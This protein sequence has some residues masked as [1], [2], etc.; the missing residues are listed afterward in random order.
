MFNETQND[1][2][3]A[4]QSITNLLELER[5]MGFQDLESVLGQIIGLDEQT[6]GFANFVFRIGTE[7]GEFFLKHRAPYIKVRPNLLR[8]RER[9][10]HEIE[11]VKVLSQILPIGTS[12]KLVYEDPD[13]F[14]FVIESLLKENGRSFDEY[15]KEGVYPLDIA[16]KLGKLLGQLHTETYNSELS[17]REP[18]EEIRFYE[19]QFDILFYS[20]S[21]P[22][23]IARTICLE[24]INKVKSTG[25]ALVIGDLSPKNIAISDGTVAL[26][27]FDAVH[28][29]NPATDLAY[30]FGHIFL[31][32]FIKGRDTEAREFIHNF[33][34]GYEEIVD[35][36]I[37]GLDAIGVINSGLVLSIATIAYRLFDAF[38]PEAS[39]LPDE[40]IA[41][42]RKFSS[43][44]CSRLA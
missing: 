16:L 37:S 27:D 9:L 13:N 30:L 23:T 17:I 25:K 19:Q 4:R 35:E 1:P 34:A 44:I 29:G 26:F 42:Y 38:V 7:N 5:Y 8:P 2:L 12:P 31:S 40:V 36:S 10:L 41:E 14:T 3:R 21:F 18:S 6:G 43:S 11:A 15:I 39:F 28:K 24:E 22:S 33:I 20:V 32:G